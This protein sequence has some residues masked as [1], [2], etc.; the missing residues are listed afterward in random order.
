MLTLRSRLAYSVRASLVEVVPKQLVGLEKAGMG[1][2]A[3]CR[4]CEDAFVPDEVMLPG[5]LD[6]A[7]RQMCN[8]QGWIAACLVVTGAMIPTTRTRRGSG[9]LATARVTQGVRRHPWQI[10]C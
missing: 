3:P 7:H 1:R 4:W 9:R 5:E 8:R 2:L 6:T 10:L